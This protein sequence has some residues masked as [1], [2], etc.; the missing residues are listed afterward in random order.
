MDLKAPVRFRGA[1]RVAGQDVVRYGDVDCAGDIEWR[2]KSDFAPK[3][4]FFPP[5]ETMF[6]LV[7][8]HWLEP[9]AETTPICMFVRACDIHGVDRLDRVFLKN[10]ND[11]DP[12]YKRTRDRIRFALIECGESLENCFCVAMGA[13]VAEEYAVAVRFLEDGGALIRVRDPD[14]LEGLPEDAQACAYTPK[15]VSEDATTVRLPDVDALTRAVRDH[16]LFDH[17]LWEPYDRRC[18]ACGRCNYSCPTC[19][20]FTTVD[21]A[22]DD[23]PQTGLRRRTWAGCHVD[24]FTTMAGGHDV[25]EKHGARMRFKSMHKIYDY[26]LRFGC[27]MCVG[28]GRCD[29]Q[30][31]E[32]ISFSACIGYVAD[33]I[34]ELE[35]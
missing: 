31:P 27:H 25:R 1:S 4:V 8:E 17:P 9:D 10:G 33:A 15:F 6:R 30:C 19:S 5:N 16:D 24:R 26:Y 22:S 7:G 29:D 13:N 35:D 11:P 3:D 23:D 32:Y 12:Y 28:C 18:I 20:C 34:D 2:H 21:A 14:L